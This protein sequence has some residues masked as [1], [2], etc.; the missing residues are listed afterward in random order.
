MWGGR[1]KKKKG[2]DNEES[3]GLINYHP[4]LSCNRAAHF[5]AAQEHLYRV[6]NYCDFTDEIAS[7]VLMESCNMRNC[8]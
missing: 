8:C 4:N 3:N 6:W 1:T 2:E 5:T 7:I